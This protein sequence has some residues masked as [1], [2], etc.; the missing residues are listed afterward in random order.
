MYKIV[1]CSHDEIVVLI[2]KGPTQDDDLA[3]CRT[4]MLQEPKW[5]P[6]I[7]LDVEAELGESYA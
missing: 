2:K 7:P 6:G 5:L 4:M 1:L 3:W